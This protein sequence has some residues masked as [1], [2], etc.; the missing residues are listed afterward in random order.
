LFSSGLTTRRAIGCWL[1]PA[2]T[3]NRRAHNTCSDEGGRADCAKTKRLAADKGSEQH[4]NHG[5][6]VG[7]AH[8]HRGPRIT[9]QPHVR[10]KADERAENNE[11]EPRKNGARTN[12]Q[13]QRLANE[14]T[15]AEHGNA[16]GQ[17]LRAGTRETCLFAF[18]RNEQRA[19]CERYRRQHDEQTPGA[20][21]YEG[22]AGAKH[23]DTENAEH[24]ADDFAAMRFLSTKCG[25]DGHHERS[26]RANGG[27]HARGHFFFGEYDKSIATK[28][29]EY[30]GG[31]GN[32]P[33]AP[34]RPRLTSQSCKAENR[35][36]GDDETCAS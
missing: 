7:V 15:Y 2:W 12:V 4:G 30:A 5:V 32:Q 23:D 1:D 24:H 31:N 14:G 17:H 34:A 19:K 9:E 28:K 21:A 29:K 26:C 33:G 6:D 35:N 25:N 20:H 18:G 13:R 8:R 3:K 16:A 27:G 11:P 36:A 22:G 10:R